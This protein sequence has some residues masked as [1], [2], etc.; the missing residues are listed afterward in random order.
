MAAIILHLGA[1]R[2]ASTHVQGVLGKNIELL[3]AHGF[4]APR[5]RL[6]HAALTSKLNDLI[7]WTPRSY[8]RF[9]KKCSAESAE[10]LLISDENLPGFLNSIFTHG[11][12]YPQSAR[13]LKR[14]AALLPEPPQKILFTIRPY[15]TFFASAYGRWLRPERPVIARELLAEL[16]LGLSRGWPDV[17]SDIAAAFPEST[18]VLNEYSSA[19]DLGPAQLH[20]LLGPLADTLFYNPGYRWN[21]SMSA[22]QTA[23]Y[24]QAIA[25]GDTAKAGEIRTWKRFKQ[26]KLVDEFWDNTTQAALQARYE[27]DRTA[28]IERFPAFVTA[29]SFEAQDAP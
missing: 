18:L 17:A 27:A 20:P 29:K 7:P 16:V 11:E 13:R 23:L 4:I 14:L 5:Q 22:R 12:F 1:H 15:N 25:E 24:E 8:G 9:L 21:R 3:S 28:L 19:P 2:T 10:N 26:P 6:L